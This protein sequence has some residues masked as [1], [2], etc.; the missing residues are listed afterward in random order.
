MT[1]NQGGGVKRKSTSDH[2]IPITNFIKS[3]KATKQKPILVF[4]DVTKAY[5]KVW[6]KASNH[7]RI[8]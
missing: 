1:P 2:L 8:G 3:N 7:V 6:S 5:D 4:L